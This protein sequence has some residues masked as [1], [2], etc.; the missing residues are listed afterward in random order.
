MTQKEVYDLLVE[1]AQPNCPKHRQLEIGEELF[2]QWYR[3]DG[4]EDM[5]EQTK[6]SIINHL[7]LFYH[8]MIEDG[9]AWML[10]QQLVF[11][12]FCSPDEVDFSLVTASVSPSQP[13]TAGS[14]SARRTGL[15]GP[16]RD[17]LMANMFSG[18]IR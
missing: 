18:G 11:Y 2:R 15:G 13:C 9:H 3:T 10:P 7:W 12:F 5:T 8:K 4:F 16:N 1:A 17:E 6:T 14:A